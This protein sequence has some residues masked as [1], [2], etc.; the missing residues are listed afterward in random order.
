D[1]D[2]AVT[3]ESDL[4]RGELIALPILLVA[5]LLVFRGVRAALL[6]LL[7]ALMT[8]AGALLLLLAA[9]SVVDVSGYA[10]DVVALF[11][12]A[13]SVDYSLL[14]VNR[15]REERRGDY[16]VTAAVVRAVQAA[17]R[18]I[19]YSALTVTAALAGLFAFGD[20]TFTSLAIGGIATTLVALLSGLFLVPALLATW[21]RRIGPQ[22]T[23]ATDAGAFGSLARGVQRRPVA[24]A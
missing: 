1:R 5:L 22:T 14:M 8:V 19:T 12:L 17:G 6:P 2:S 23:A 20:P 21:G 9:T 13:L 11:G 10:V 4:V 3:S 7:A 15:F 24:V 16:P 18:T